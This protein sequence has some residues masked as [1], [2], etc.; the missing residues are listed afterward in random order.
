MGCARWTGA[1]LLR[2]AK[3]LPLVK[4]DI[5]N[6]DE[7]LRFDI[8]CR[9]NTFAIRPSL[10]A[11]MFFRRR[12]LSFNGSPGKYICVTMRLIFPVTSKCR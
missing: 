7:R 8:G 4:H 10:F 12:S 2:R 1:G 11:R 5:P 6:H 9:G 3:T